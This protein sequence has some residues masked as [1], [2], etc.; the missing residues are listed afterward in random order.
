M[1]C[2]KRKEWVSSPEFGTLD[3]RNCK[4]ATTSK[5]DWF[6]LRLKSYEKQLFAK[7]QSA[8]L[9]PAEFLLKIVENFNRFFYLKSMAQ[10]CLQ[11]NSSHPLRHISKH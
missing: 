11:D 8:E 6:G 1:L 2:G 10:I 9:K 3:T 7:N 5:L 4:N